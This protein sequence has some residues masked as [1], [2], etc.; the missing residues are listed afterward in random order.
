MINLNNIYQVLIIKE[1]VY[2]DCTFKY[3][4]HVWI[5]LKLQFLIH[6]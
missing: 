5:W 6:I 3:I 4:K 1:S 2:R